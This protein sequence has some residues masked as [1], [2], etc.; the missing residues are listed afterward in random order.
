[1]PWTPTDSPDP[2]EILS[3]A[4]EDT[5]NG[6]FEE[7][8]A[9]H[10][11][12]HHN[13]LLWDSSLTSGGKVPSFC[14]WASL[15]DQY[16]PAKE[17]FRRVRD[18]TEALF[19]INPKNYNV[20]FELAMM[21]NF[22]GDWMRTADLFSQAAREH[23]K[24]A[25]VMYVNA[26]L[27]LV[28]TGRFQECG[29][30]LDTRRLQYAQECYLISLDMAKE[31]PSFGPHARRGF[32]EDVTKLVGLLV[33]NHREEDAQWVCDEALKVMDDEEFR[34]KLSIAKTG[35]L[36]PSSFVTRLQD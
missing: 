2:M 30:F 13:A 5:Q 23:P 36:S 8:L 33:L 24:E 29:P 31:D 19:A 7:A 3:S 9:K 17:A 14:S 25:K 22:L 6:R 26:E 34:Q 1:M 35:H 12:F 20:F 27:S 32:I 4:V 11:W 21:N 16:P 10:L 15:A 18:E 28:A